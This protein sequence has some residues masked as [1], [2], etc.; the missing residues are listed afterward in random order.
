VGPGLR[1]G[2]GEGEGLGQREGQEDPEQPL[3]AVTA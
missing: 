2:Q 3:A 1:V